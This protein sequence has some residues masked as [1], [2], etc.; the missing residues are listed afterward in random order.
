MDANSALWILSTIAQGLMVLL[1][2]AAAL[3]IFATGVAK[4]PSPTRLDLVIG[5]VSIFI[6]W[7]VLIAHLSAIFY[8]LIFMA[9]VSGMSGAVLDITIFWAIVLAAIAFTSLILLFRITLSASSRNLTRRL[10]KSH[11]KRIK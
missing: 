3:V 9:H 7:P 6:F 8:C 2:V 10:Q 1:G 4:G 5:R 11:R